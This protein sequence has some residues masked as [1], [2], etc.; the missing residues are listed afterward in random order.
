MSSSDKPEVVKRSRV[1][2]VRRVLRSPE[3]VALHKV[4]VAAELVQVH[5]RG[6][7]HP[8]VSIRETAAQSEG[9]PLQAPGE[10]LGTLRLQRHLLLEVL[11][12]EK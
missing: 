9:D 11:H 7:H 2:R 10:P 5:A 8:H 1:S 4:L 12:R 6:S 3:H